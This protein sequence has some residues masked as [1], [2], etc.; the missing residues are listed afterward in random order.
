MVLTAV[1]YMTVTCG[2]V[3]SGNIDLGKPVSK[4]L[5][6][7]GVYYLFDDERTDFATDS[8]TGMFSA[9]LMPGMTGDQSTESPAPASGVDRAGT[10]GFGTGL[11]FY[12]K[13]DSPSFGENMNSSL[14]FE[15]V[16][17]IPA[18]QFAYVMEN[19][20]FTVGCWVKFASEPKYSNGGAHMVLI[21]CGSALSKLPHWTLG[22]EIKRDGDWILMFDVGNGEELSHVASSS[23]GSM[24]FS[25]LQWHHVAASFD[26]DT[27]N[28][29]LYFDGE[30]VGTGNLKFGPGPFTTDQG[31]Y[32]DKTLRIGERTARAFMSAS[33]DA[34]VDDVFITS[35]VHTFAPPV[36]K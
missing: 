2:F 26:K 11:R 15:G 13:P 33:F 1:G 8:V 4:S 3:V 21:T 23:L 34:T 16:N 31:S 18:S 32:I 10:S 35:G 7:D 27:L 24:I 22:F 17:E 36:A 5:D 28:V 14:R 25:D 19:S 20:S 12:G 29:V 6:V 30:V 9:A